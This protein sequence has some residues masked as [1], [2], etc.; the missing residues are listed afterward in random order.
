MG[1]GNRRLAREVL[2]TIL[3]QADILNSYESQQIVEVMESLSTELKLQKLVEADKKF[4]SEYVK[5]VQEHKTSLLAT[6]ESKMKD[7]NIERVGSVERI[8]LLIAA[9]EL[10]MKLDINYTIV[11]NEAVELGKCYGDDKTSS[12]I[13]G[14]LAKFVK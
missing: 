1:E 14:V 4:I 3:Y 11:I 7:W 13:N 8:I 5:E 9:Y 6:L 12:F 10:T 2:F